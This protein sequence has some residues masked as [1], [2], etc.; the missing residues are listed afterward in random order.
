MWNVQTGECLK[1]L[2]TDLSGV[3]QVKFD[4]RRCV[5]AVQR[6]SLTYIEASPLSSFMAFEFTNAFQVLDFGASRDGI[7][8]EDR[9]RRILLQP[10]DVDRITEEDD[11]VP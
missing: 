9:G 5:A 1:D 6:D 8:V 4:E 10:S 11:F 3:W 2:L 7:P